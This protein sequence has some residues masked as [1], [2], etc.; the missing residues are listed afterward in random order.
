V[1]TSLGA[2]P[3]PGGPTRA[4]IARRWPALALGSVVLAVIA[5]RAAAAFPS[6]ERSAVAA[7]APP[8][9][10]VGYVGGAA[11]TPATTVDE[12]PTEARFSG[13]VGADL[14]QSL[15]AAGVPERSGREYVALL[16]RAIDLNNALSVEDKFDLVV[17]REEDG[18]LGQLIYAGLDRVARADVELLKWTD[19]KRIIWVNA[20]GIG[21]E[22]A[23]AMHLPVSGRVTSAFGSRFHPILGYARMHKGVDLAARMGAPI[24]AAAD[25]RVVSA[26][27]HGGYGRQI[28]I[29][30]RDGV[31]TTYGHMSRMVAYAGEAVRQGQL[32][33]YV[34]SSGLS[35]GPHVHYEVLKNGRPVNPMSVKLGGGPGQLEGEKLRQFQD[36][37]RSVLSLNPSRG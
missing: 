31:E 3:T 4:A 7:P 26:G 9:T 23:S 29:A 21:G 8:P 36:A 19:G 11:P 10:P 37:L 15:Q 34:G 22:Q 27:W 28:I 12:D 17:Q 35:T 33:G 20:D 5:I 1:L 16:R 32:I 18:K 6:S 24:V 14:T 25:G 13:R 30:H 2:R